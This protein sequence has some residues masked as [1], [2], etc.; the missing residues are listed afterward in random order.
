MDLELSDINKT[1][2][3]KKKHDVTILHISIKIGALC[4]VYTEKHDVSKWSTGNEGG[5]GE[6]VGRG[7]IRF[8]VNLS[9][10]LEG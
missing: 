8:K 2:I 5:G 1:D 7:T 9:V 6:M 3:N 4:S 10:A